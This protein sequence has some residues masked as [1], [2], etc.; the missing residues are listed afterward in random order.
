MLPTFVLPVST[1]HVESFQ[2]REGRAGVD[3]NTFSHFSQSCESLFPGTLLPPL[4]SASFYTCMYATC[5]KAIAGKQSLLPCEHTQRYV[6]VFGLK[7]KTGRKDGLFLVSIICHIFYPILFSVTMVNKN[8]SILE[9]C[10]WRTLMWILHVYYMND[11][12]VDYISIT[13][14]KGSGPLETF[15]HKKVVWQLR[16]RAGFAGMLWSWYPKWLEFRS[17]GK[18]GK[19]SLDSPAFTIAR[20]RGALVPFLRCCGEDVCFSLFSPR[21]LWAFPCGEDPLLDIHIRAHE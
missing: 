10:G 4:L 11:V 12:Q 8:V 1:P 16:T 20:M 7:V 9:K 6:S 19:C 21:V 15:W 18:T 3:C 2:L 17:T 13:E 14:K 5:H